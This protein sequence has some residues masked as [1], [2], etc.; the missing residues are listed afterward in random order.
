MSDKFIDIDL[1]ISNELHREYKK[2]ARS[3]GVP[4]KNFI[5]VILFMSVGQLRRQL[6]DIRMSKPEQ[7]MDE[8]K[9]RLDAGD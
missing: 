5:S 2:M 1:K 6:E 4:V 7:R 8:T 9:E 3:C